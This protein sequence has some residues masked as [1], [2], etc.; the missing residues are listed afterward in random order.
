MLAWLAELNGM[1]EEVRGVGVPSWGWLS[2]WVVTA[3]QARGQSAPSPRP[4]QPSSQPRPIL[5]A[6]LAA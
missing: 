6:A 4:S 2:W 5:A 3:C 1:C